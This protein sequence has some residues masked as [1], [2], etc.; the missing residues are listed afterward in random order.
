MY[1]REFNGINGIKGLKWGGF[2]YKHAS[3]QYSWKNEDSSVN[4]NSILAKTATKT[5]IMIIISANICIMYGRK[6][7]PHCIDFSLNYDGHTSC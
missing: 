7:K 6:K 3:Q 4:S 2:P 1:N 5:I